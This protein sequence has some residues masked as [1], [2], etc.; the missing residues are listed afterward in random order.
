MSPQWFLP[1]GAYDTIANAMFK[2]R[3]T[4]LADRENHAL[5]LAGAVKPGVA[6]RPGA[7][8]L[9]QEPGRRVPRQRPRPDVPT[10]PSAADGREL[11]AAGRRSGDRRRGPADAD[12]G[13]GARRRLP[14]PRQPA[15][16]ARLGAAQ[17]DRDPSGAR[18]RAAADRPAADRRRADAVGHR[19][20]VSACVASWWTAAGLAAWLSSVVTFGVDFVVEPSPRLVVAA[21]LFALLSTVLFA[22]GPAWSLSRTDRDRRSQACARPRAPA[23]GQRLGARRAAARGVARAGRGRRIVRARRRQ[24]DGGGRR[25]PA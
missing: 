20:R 23:R 21:A 22:L 3:E 4:G 18:Q 10:R 13:P 2:Q 17:G 14:Q 1:I 12:G 6:R 8:R 11:A 15:A 9:R 7:R 24:C 16:R 25:L 5:N 19:R